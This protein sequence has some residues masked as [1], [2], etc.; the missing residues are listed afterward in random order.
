MRIIA[1]AP[2]LETL[3]G[4]A[5]RVIGGL[6]PNPSFITGMQDQLRALVARVEEQLANGAADEPTRARYERARRDALARIDDYPGTHLVL[7]TESFADELVID[8]AERPVRL[9]FLG[10]ANTDGDAFAWLPEQ[11]ILVA[12]D[13]VVAPIP[14][15]T[16]S[17]AGDWIEVLERLEAMPFA[18]L[19]PGH[20]EPL[21]DTAF[22]QRLIAALRDL[23]SQVG[24]LAGEGLSLEEIRAR[25]DKSIQMNLFGDTPR[26]RAQLEAFW[27]SGMIEN[28]YRE[29][30]GLPIP[31]GE[32]APE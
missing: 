28:A 27:L 3:S 7:P 19:I 11:R 5:R 21:S 25:Y 26:H 16:Q 18:M 9:M 30:V 24:R 17:Y 12:G 20:G 4:P 2:T 29:A 23:R 6:E 1:T 10:R 8:D 15:G 22:I 13:V 32:D 14:F 31:Q